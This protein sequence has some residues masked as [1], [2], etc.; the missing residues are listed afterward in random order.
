MFDIGF[1]ELLLIAVISLLVL[2][3]ERLPGA[4][5]TA[6]LWIGRARRM[7]AEVQQDIQ[8]QIAT[9]DLHKK[10][11]AE[12]DALGLDKMASSIES[13]IKETKALGSELKETLEESNPGA[14]PE[15]LTQDPPEGAPVNEKPGSAPGQAK[16][17]GET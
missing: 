17:N 11:E 10:I 12:K 6:G 5:R 2:G 9:E 4:A 3:P 16:E 15:T 1:A 8:Q 7:M 14:A 13:S